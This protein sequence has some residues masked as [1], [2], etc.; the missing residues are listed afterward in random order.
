MKHNADTSTTGQN[1]KKNS[2]YSF[3]I[4][5]IDFYVMFDNSSYLKKLK[6]LYIL[7]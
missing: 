2:F 3:L 1:N 7:L 5:V 4:V 6:L